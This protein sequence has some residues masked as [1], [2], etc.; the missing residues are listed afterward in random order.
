MCK[1]FELVR[2]KIKRNHF[3]NVQETWDLGLAESNREIK[4]LTKDDDHLTAL[5][6][7]IPDMHDCATKPANFYLKT[8]M[9]ATSQR[10]AKNV[11][12][13]SQKDQ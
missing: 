5:R 11:S 3:K 4:I 12:K 2:V 10:K 13:R 1:R 8:K 7:G 9:R 6:I